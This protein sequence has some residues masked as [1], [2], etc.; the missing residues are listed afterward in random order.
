MEFNIERVKRIFSMARTYDVSTYEKSVATLFVD[1]S[2]KLA[3]TIDDHIGGKAVLWTSA[4]KV[5]GKRHILDIDCVNIVFSKELEKIVKNYVYDVRRITPIDKVTIL[6][7]DDLKTT[8]A[9]IAYHVKKMGLTPIISK[10]MNDEDT[11]YIT[12]NNLSIKK[13]KCLPFVFYQIEQSNNKCFDTREYIEDMDSS[14]QIW[15]CFE[16]V[17]PK[18]SEC[19]TRPIRTLALPFA[20]IFTTKNV[21]KEY[22]IIF[23]GTINRRRK[24]L[25]NILSRNFNLKI[26]EG[27]Y[28]NERDKEI[29]KA[30]FIINLHYYDNAELEIDRVNIGILNGVRTLSECTNST[31]SNRYTKFIKFFAIADTIG[32]TTSMITFIKREIQNYV[33]YSRNFSR[34]S[35]KLTV[36]CHRDFKDLFLCL[37]Y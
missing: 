32:S 17:K 31:I 29:Q 8:A 11:L 1:P 2:K 13:N 9:M 37:H 34:E 30:K 21:K 18:Y 36:E 3:T 25:L 35:E 33:P 24:I 4:E 22:D 20:P 5:I 19:V 27:V 16:S 28:G 23:F 10:E 14:L 7:L 6:T 26:L 12:L 15:E